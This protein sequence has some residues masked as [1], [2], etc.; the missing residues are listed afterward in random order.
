[1]CYYNAH[2]Q[3]LRD[4]GRGWGNPTGSGL[5]HSTADVAPVVR[6]ADEQASKSIRY[7]DANVILFFNSDTR[8]YLLMIPWRPEWPFQTSMAV[9]TRSFTIMG[10]QRQ[11]TRLDETVLRLVTAPDR[12][13]KK[14]WAMTLMATTSWKPSSDASDITLNSVVI[15]ASMSLYW[16]V[17]LYIVTIEKSMELML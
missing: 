13:L 15:L 17:T 7:D 11:L 5:Q 12:C 14:Q 4:T 6:P 8:P 3:I 16:A 10:R 9:T 2:R 1:M